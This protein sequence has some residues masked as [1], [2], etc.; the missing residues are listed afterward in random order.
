M[1]REEA[2]ETVFTGIRLVS[3]RVEEGYDI[4]ATGEMGI[5]NTTTSSAVASVLLDQP[6]ELLTGRGAGLSGEGLK[7]KKEVIKKALSVHRPDR[8]DPLDVL[9]KVGGFDL[10]GLTGVFLGSAIYRIPVVID[11]FISAVAAL[12]AVKLCP[13]SRGFMLAS[14][15]SR[16]PGMRLIMKELQME[17][18]LDC[19]MCLGEGTGAVAFFPVLDLGV[20]VYHRMSTFSDNNIEEYRELGEDI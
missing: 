13:G 12:A 9:A 1:S 11:G 15:S 8:F 17:P 19:E 3:E 20:E 10:A 14:H 16:E 2:L 4:L 5:G 7:K 6:P 18:P